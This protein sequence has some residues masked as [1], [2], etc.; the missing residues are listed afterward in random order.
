MRDLGLGVHNLDT[1]A[2]KVYLTNAAPNAATHTVKA[3]LAEIG[4]GNGYTA[5]G[6]D[7]TG[8]MRNRAAQARLPLRT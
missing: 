3:D 5:G 7:I 2:L 8:V 4:A 1:G 6:A